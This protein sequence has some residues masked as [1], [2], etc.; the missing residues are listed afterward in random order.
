MNSITIKY[1]PISWLPF[2]RSI[3]GVFPNEYAELGK[4]QFL[5]LIKLMNGFTGENEFVSKITGI[6]ARVIKKVAPFLVYKIMDLLAEF[7]TT[8]PHNDFIIKTIKSRGILFYP[9]P[10]K[11]K[12]MTFGQFIFTE[13]LYETW[14][15]SKNQTDLCRF[16]A[17]LYSP[18]QK[19]FHENNIDKYQSYFVKVKPE[20][21]EAVA[22]NWKL[23]TQWLADAY[24]LVF[25]KGEDSKPGKKTNSSGWIKIFDS[26]VGD[27]ITETD[28]YAALPV[29]NV[30]RYMSAKIKQDIKRK[31]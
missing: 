31:K 13:S 4:Q 20:I 24:P 29:N 30:L 8:K 9:P 27:N 15:T 11:L 14:A 16:V 23:V 7:N 18:A 12:G 17:S 28:R 5:A 1:R 26:I 6:P 10:T 22:I 21:C 3:T 19:P 2:N 25:M